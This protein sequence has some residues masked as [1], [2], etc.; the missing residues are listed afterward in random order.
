MKRGKIKRMEEIR[1]M[2]KIVR[3]F[4]KNRLSLALKLIDK[5]SSGK[6]TEIIIKEI[7]ESG[8]KKEVELGRELTDSEWQEIVLK[9]KKNEDEFGDYLAH[10]EASSY[11]KEATVNRNDLVDLYLS[12]CGK[13][14]LE[15]HE[16]QDFRGKLSNKELHQKKIEINS[17]IQSCI[18][19]TNAF[20]EEDQENKTSIYLT[21]KGK[22]FAGMDGLIK[23]EIKELGITR[24]VILALILGSIGGFVSKNTWELFKFLWG[25][26][27]PNLGL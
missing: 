16:K 15:R 10:R 14:I 6:A 27:K 3:F 4:K 13:E 23:E 25:S 20:I 22:K 26:I 11:H 1:D 2:W 21:G 17:I 19:K 8:K 24:S 5:K 9:A 7:K 18:A 12:V